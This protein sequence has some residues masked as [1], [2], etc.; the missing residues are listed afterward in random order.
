MKKKLF[1]LLSGCILSATIATCLFVN[2]IN[3]SSSADLLASNVEALA[4]DEES[5]CDSCDFTYA[6]GDS[7]SACC[8][9]GRRA[10]CSS[11]GCGCYI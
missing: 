1:L 4:Q 7:C 3:I 9:S 10:H 11:A 8:S 6:N 2:S 5:G